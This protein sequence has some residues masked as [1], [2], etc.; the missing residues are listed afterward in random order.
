MGKSNCNYNNYLT[1]G[2]QVTLMNP[3][4]PCM[5]MQN[6]KHE[7]NDLVYLLTLTLI[8][9]VLMCKNISLTILARLHYCLG[10]V[11]L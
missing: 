11:K 3:I 9:E 7:T 10:M 2:K 1:K 6:L 4:P 8:R 5:P